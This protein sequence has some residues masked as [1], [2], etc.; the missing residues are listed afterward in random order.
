ME[1][2]HIAWP[3]ILLLTYPFIFSLSIY[4]LISLISWSWSWSVIAYFIFSVFSSIIHWYPHPN[5]DQGKGEGRSPHFHIL[6]FIFPYFQIFFDIPIP[7]LIS[8]KAIRQVGR[9]PS[10]SLNHCLFPSNTVSFDDCPLFFFGI[11]WCFAFQDS[12]FSIFF[13]VFC[14]I[15]SISGWLS[16]FLIVF[17]IFFGI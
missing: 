10:S 7:I 9:C 15:C 17:F 6:Y 14:D 8:A 3:L 13:G 5:T 4:S 16:P 12:F 11:F 2:T 1:R